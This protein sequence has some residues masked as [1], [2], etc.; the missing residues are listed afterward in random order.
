MALGGGTCSGPGFQYR[1]NPQPYKQPPRRGVSGCRDIDT[2]DPGGCIVAA[3]E[4]R[5]QH[6]GQA[7]IIDELRLA[8]QQLW[9]FVPE[10]G[11]FEIFSAT[12]YLAF[13]VGLASHC[14]SSLFDCSDD[15][16]IS[17][18][19][20]EIAVDRFTDFFIGGLRVVTQERDDRH[21][22]TGRAETALQGMLFHEGLLQWMQCILGAQ[23]F[24]G[25]DGMP[26]GLTAN[27]RQE[28][29]DSP[30]MRIVQAPHIPCSQPTWVPVSSRS[31]RRKSLSSKR[32]STVRS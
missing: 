29:T 9:I 25:F 1:Q 5:V 13:S 19:A 30:S 27:I 6:A 11:L 15:V 17:G 21:Q 12:D 16:F 26:V 2:F 10:N 14:C 3:L 7:D 8:G 32:G 4:G 20:A 23:T 28:R 22:E 18:A 24:N 31:W